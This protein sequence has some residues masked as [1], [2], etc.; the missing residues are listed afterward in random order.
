MFAHFQLITRAVVSVLAGVATLLLPALTIAAETS[1]A[2]KQVSMII[3]SSVGGGTDATGRL[4]GEYLVKYLPGKPDIINRNMPGGGGIIGLNYF[5]RQAK[6]DG[7]TITAASSSHPDPAHWRSKNSHYD[8]TK[9]RVVGGVGR[10]GNVLI[11]RK[12]VLARVTDKSKPPVIMGDVDGTRVG[13]LMMLWGIE[14][15]GW[16]AKWVI[17]YPGTAD[18]MLAL[19]RGEIDVTATASAFQ[20]VE[21]LSTGKYVVLAQSGTVTDGGLRPRPEFG[22]A[23]LFPNL[24]RPKLKTERAKLAF[25]Y[26]DAINTLD[27][28]VALPEGTPDEIVNTYRAAFRK[29]AQDPEFLARG[30]KIS[31][32]FDPVMPEDQERIIRQVALTP[33]EALDYIDE[34]KKKQGLPVIKR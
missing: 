34:L 7:L 19:Q 12:E 18:L 31:E 29:A 14:Y 30:K 15:L 33:L 6:P 1:F 21:L 13:M 32:D 23:P 20:V 24:I 11:I 28:W 26:W 8:P 27:K 4:I 10:G 3:G 17:G 16:N 9:F 5:A 25:E 22:D 2:G